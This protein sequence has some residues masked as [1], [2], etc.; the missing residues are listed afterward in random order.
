MPVQ[1]SS[2]PEA[3][4]AFERTN[5]NKVISAYDRLFTALTVQTVDRLIEAAGVSAGTRVLDVC[6]GQ[7]V[8]AAAAAARAARVSGIDF[9]ADAI[10]IARRNVPN[11]EF[12][13]GDA[14]ALPYPTDTFD[15]VLCSYGIMH[16]PEPDRALAEFYRVLKP[17]GRAAI[18]VWQAPA[19]GN[20]YGLMFG[21]LKRHGRMDVQLPNGPD[22]FQFS[23][24]AALQDILRHVG[25]VDVH[26]GAVP[27]HWEMHRPGDLLDAILQG[28]VRLRALLL[29][30][31][32]LV[33]AAIQTEV[34]DGMNRLFRDGDVYRV[35]MPAT[36]G[37]GRKP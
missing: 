21:A 20:G 17:G 13:E 30:Q 36:V 8:L 33:L 32:P 28:A 14:Q 3:F 5:W 16:F 7:G 11:A 15:S 9:A 24:P 23:D 37:S 4:L 34:E 26:A 22:F 2:E 6:T 18:S 35:P 27:Q 31:D 10:A 29:A 1:R 25:F 12:E 19:P